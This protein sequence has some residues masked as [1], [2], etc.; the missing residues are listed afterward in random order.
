M[1]ISKLIWIILLSFNRLDTVNICQ[2]DYKQALKDVIN[3]K[4]VIDD[5]YIKETISNI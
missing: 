3:V 1:I 4:N 2:L 5:N